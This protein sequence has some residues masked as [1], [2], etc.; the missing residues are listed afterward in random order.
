MANPAG[1]L[2]LS[3]SLSCLA[4]P[5]LV[6]ASAQDKGT[7]LLCFDRAATLHTVQIKI[8]ANSPIKYALQDF[9]RGI[10]L[11]SKSQTLLKVRSNTA[12]QC[13]SACC[14]MGTA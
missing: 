10:F 9:Q 7:K 1:C 12:V 14:C 2:A 3:V 13:F 4:G 8:P 6:S 11:R 5:L